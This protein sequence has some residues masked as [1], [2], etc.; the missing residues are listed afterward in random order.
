VTWAN[1]TT[2]PK[3]PTNL[4][5]SRKLR[6][7]KQKK[8]LRRSSSTL[9]WSASSRITSPVLQAQP[10]R[11]QPNLVPLL[12]ETRRSHQP[13]RSTMAILGIPPPRRLNRH[14]HLVARPRRPPHGSPTLRRRPLQRLQTRHRR[15]RNKQTQ[16]THVCRKDLVCDR[17]RALNRLCAVLLEY[18]PA[19]EAAFDYAMVKAAVVLLTKYATPAA[20]AG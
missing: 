9:T 11:N 17:T 4:Q 13:A 19:L 14:E 2:S 3:Y 18:F 15:S 10:Q 12:V 6:N 20:S 8:P 7:R 1:G 16:T 5:G